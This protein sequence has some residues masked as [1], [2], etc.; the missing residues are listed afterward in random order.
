MRVVKA[1]EHSA[2]VCVSFV[3][4]FLANAVESDLG[5]CVE[6][7]L[8]LRNRAQLCLIHVDRYPWMINLLGILLPTAA[9]L[10]YF[11]G[12]NTRPVQ[13]HTSL[14]NT[15]SGQHALLTSV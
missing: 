9:A 11:L 8:Q 13:A 2:D 15:L 6:K 3:V 10:G 4:V 1:L 12:G 14:D 5:R 7:V